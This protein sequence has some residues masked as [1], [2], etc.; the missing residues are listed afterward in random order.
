MDN[1]AYRMMICSSCD[2]SMSNLQN[3]SMFRGHLF[4]AL[5]ELANGHLLRGLRTLLKP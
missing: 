1:P 4:A 5:V 3:N 2:C